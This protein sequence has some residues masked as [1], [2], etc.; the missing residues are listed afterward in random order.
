MADFRFLAFCHGGFPSP[1]GRVAPMHICGIC[2]H[3][4][5]SR[6]LQLCR[7]WLQKRDKS[8]TPVLQLHCA[9]KRRS[10]AED[11]SLQMIYMYLS[12]P[13]GSKRVQQKKVIEVGFLRFF[14]NPFAPRAPTEVH[15]NHLETS[16]LRSTAP[17]RSAVKL[18]DWSL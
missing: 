13:Y 5:R 2:L 11:W 14:F 3:T 8:E 4:V 10:G 9:A 17:L 12:G 15:I 6:R 18:E 16:V 7:M 1:G